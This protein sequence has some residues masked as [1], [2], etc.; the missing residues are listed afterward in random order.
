MRI[1]YDPVPETPP[2]TGGNR[3]RNGEAD[4]TTMEQ[5]GLEKVETL[6]DEIREQPAGARSGR[7]TPRWRR[8][9]IGMVLPVLLLLGGAA[10]AYWLVITR[11]GTPERPPRPVASLVTVTPVEPATEQV[12]VEAMG[13]VVPARETVIMPQVSGRIEWISPEFMIGGRFQQ[14]QEMLRIEKRDYELALEQRRSDV[15]RAEYDVKLEE[16]QQIIARA[17]LNATGLA[18]ESEASRELML[19]KP[20]LKRF[21]AA[22]AAARASLEAA[23]LDLERTAVRAPFNAV[24]TEQLV[25]VGTQVSTQTRLVT[26]VGTDAYWVKVSLPVEKLAWIQVPGAPGEV[27]ARAQ[28][29]QAGLGPEDVRTGRVLRSL[30][31]LETEGR[32]ANLLVEV[33]NPLDLDR[34]AESS[35]P[36]LLLGAYV[37]V[38]IE[39]RTLSDVVAVPRRAVHEGNLLWIMTPE[40]TLEIR[41]VDIVWRDRDRALVAQGLAAG[42]RVVTSAIPTPVNG[43]R[44]RVAGGDGGDG[45]DGASSTPALGGN[46]P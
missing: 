10:G 5:Y 31:S 11:P 4:M 46:Q 30:A 37:Q 20:H 33:K 22:L 7:A 28:V 16:G 2:R 35:R 42:E 19:R 43:L 3:E 15:A 41:P 26:L 39:G 9:L 8:I 40:D 1:E 18:V 29:R 32:L 13:T 45:G 44:L 21:Q 14:G 38:A 12:T 25:D 36:P 17:E 6:E 24:V 23:E 27:G 34:P